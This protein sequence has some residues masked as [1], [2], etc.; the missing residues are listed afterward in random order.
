VGFPDGVGYFFA[1]PILWSPDA[2]KG[3]LVFPLARFLWSLHAMAVSVDYRETYAGPEFERW[4]HARDLIEPEQFL[5]EQYLEKEARTLEA[6]T[7]GGRILREMA[8]RGFSSLE[9][10]DGV[11]SLIEVARKMDPSGTVRF[12]VQDARQL[13]YEAECFAQI[14]YLQQLICHITEPVGRRKAVTE[15]CR[16]LK[17]GGV[18]L[19]SFLLYEARLQSLSYKAVIAYLAG[20]R[21]VL[22][23]RAS[24]Q[25]MPWLSHQGKF[26]RAA[27]LD[28]PPYVYWFRCEEAAELLVSEGFAITGIG[29]LSQIRKGGLCSSVKELL[30][31]PLEGMLYVVCQKHVSARKN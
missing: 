11:P 2:S 31:E 29:T 25:Y 27:L 22:G 26:N 6:G 8:R 14:I 13:W 15:A 23:R 18:A 16:V 10:F 5:I 20:L 3:F 30:K 28:R 24:A 21:V 19:F 12:T 4:A 1:P 9:G 7:G 17:P